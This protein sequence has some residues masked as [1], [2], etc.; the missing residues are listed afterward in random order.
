[1]LHEDLAE[2]KVDDAI[3]DLQLQY[4]IV[5]G[6]FA[7]RKFRECERSQTAALISGSG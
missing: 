7:G 4:V 1:M 5:L 6:L 3:I 2:C